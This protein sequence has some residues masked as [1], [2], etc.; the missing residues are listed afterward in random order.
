M[1]QSAAQGRREEPAS[2]A[3]VMV[4]GPRGSEAATTSSASGLGTSR[5]N[6]EASANIRQIIMTLTLLLSNSGQSD[7][8]LA[9]DC[10]NIRGSVKA[11]ALTPQEGCWSEQPGHP[12]PESRDG[13][14]LW[15]RDGARFPIVRCKMTETAMRADCDA[16]GR[17][18]VWRVTPSEKQVPMSPM[19]C[20]EI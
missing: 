10:R 1:Q 7:E 15:I 11:Y 5:L 13:R 17:I 18:G 12:V 16:T 2:K 20:L 3:T 4:S 8:L 6:Q 14:I 9:Y 19:S